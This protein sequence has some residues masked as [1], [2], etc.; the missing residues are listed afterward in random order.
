MKIPKKLKIGGHTYSVIYPYHFKE[1]GDISGQHDLDVLEIRVD[2]RDGWSHNAR[3]ES[4]VAETFLHEILHACDTI[5]GHNV[6]KSNESAI[7]GISQLL[8]Q[9]LRDNKLRFD[10][11]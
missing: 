9:V 4:T 8:F 5:S 2:D 11:E 10:E 1:R 7:T 3:P 6:F